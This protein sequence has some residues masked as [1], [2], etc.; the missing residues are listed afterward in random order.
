[1]EKEDVERLLEEV[2]N[3]SIEKY[4]VLI[5]HFQ[6]QIFRYCYH[7]LDH[8]QEAEDAVQ[9]VFLKAYEH[10]DQYIYSQSF[11]AWLY[12]IAYNHCVNVL[13]RQKMR[14]LL[15]FLYHSENDGRNFV[16]EKIDHY[17]LNEPLQ[18]VWNKLSSEERNIMIL[19]VLEEKS[20]EEISELTNKKT[21]AL[22]KQYERILKKCKRYL[23]RT[24]GIINEGQRSV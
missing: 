4:G 9:D 16:E 3:G 24:G 12:R 23:N 5:N 11:S 6:Q 13:K 2:K 17:Y 21:T 19:R 7:M 1:M 22:R 15:P 20:Y 18:K 10:L 14:R 8:T